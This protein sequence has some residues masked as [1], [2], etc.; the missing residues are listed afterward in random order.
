MSERDYTEEQQWDEYNLITK[1][2]EDNLIVIQ[3]AIDELGNVR[4]RLTLDYELKVLPLMPV[5]NE[6]L[7][8]MAELQVQK[9]GEE[10]REMSALEE[11]ND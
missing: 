9:Y 10:R 2:Y 1:E 6:R 7:S 11:P 8:E 5:V 3:R 4:K